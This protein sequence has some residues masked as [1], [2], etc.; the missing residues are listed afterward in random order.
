[1]KQRKKCA[2]VSVWKGSVDD[3]GTDTIIRCSMVRVADLDSA[4]DTT[5]SGVLELDITKL[6][7]DSI[8]RSGFMGLRSNISVKLPLLK[9]GSFLSAFETKR[10]VVK[11]FTERYNLRKRPLRTQLTTLLAKAGR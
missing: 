8:V 9:F 7:P 11:R 1:M 6:L 4:E 5:C 3:D 10:K 2:R